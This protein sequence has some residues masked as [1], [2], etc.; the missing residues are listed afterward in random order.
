MN[1]QKGDYHWEP[2]NLNASKIEECSKKLEVMQGCSERYQEERSEMVEELWKICGDISESLFYSNHSRR[3]KGKRKVKMEE[4]VD[5]TFKM[6]Q[7]S[8]MGELMT[9]GRGAT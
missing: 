5:D 4:K 3:L 6:L 9:V 7:E 2:F 8:I 1:G